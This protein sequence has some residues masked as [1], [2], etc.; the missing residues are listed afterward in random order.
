MTVPVPAV[1]TD[2]PQGLKSHPDTTNPYPHLGFNPVPGSTELVRA[3]HQRLSSCAKEM[4]RAHAKVTKLMA[5]SYWEGDAAVA[6][7]EQLENG[8]LP[9]NL[10]NG[11]HSVRKAAKQLD[12]W[13]GE[14]EDYQRR[15]KKLDAEARDARD[16]LE[17]AQGHAATAKNAPALK[18]GKSGK[19]KAYDDANTALAKAD[20]AVIN[21]QGDLDG[22]LN[23]ARTLATDHETTARDRARNIG[24]ATHKLAPHEPSAWDKF[25]DWL[26][27]N[28]PDILS[29][30]AAVLGVI[31]LI[32]LT[33]IAPWV[34][35]LAAGLLSGVA[36][37]MRVS[38]AD[39]RASIE[40]GPSDPDFWSNTLGVTGDALGMLPGLGAALKG[41]FKGVQLV[42]ESGELLSLAGGADEVLTLGQKI[43]RVGTNT[44]TSAKTVGVEIKSQA[45]AAEG[46]LSFLSHPRVLGGR[47]APA[48]EKV[49]KPA[50]FLGA[51]TAVFGVAAS[52]VKSL[53]ND[54]ANKI[55]NV[56][57][58]TRTVAVDLPA[59]AGALHFLIAGARG[60]S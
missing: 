19:D 37:T 12:L 10:Q 55:I 35:F 36:F 22:V 7:R 8:P 59:T 42:G 3:L 49:D 34:L 5:G 60:A 1:D 58:S 38:D 11:A 23:R 17:R 46:A 56:L 6:F 18:K 9:L 30:C 44:V 25:G 33:A 4:E 57:D 48:V 54:T 28:L 40:A 52:S 14:L 43:A 13:T 15:A 2:L 51:G 21:A 45:Q 47:L 16:A 26:G 53:D 50:T 24:D 20:A 31:A 39:V 41:G 29:A 32:G 27:D